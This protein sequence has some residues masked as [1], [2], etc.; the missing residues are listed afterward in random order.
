MR[1]TF[2]KTLLL[3]TTAFSMIS[4]PAANAYLFAAQL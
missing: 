3:A 1:I 2:S 4:V